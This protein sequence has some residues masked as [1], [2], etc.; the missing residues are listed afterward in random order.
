MIND[1]LLPRRRGRPPAFDRDQVLERAGRTFWRLGYE[2]ASI[3]DLTAAMGLTPQSL[4]AAF[5]SKA[6]LYR[7]TLRRY[8]ATSGAFTP[9]ALREEPTA[10]AAFGRALREAAKQYTRADQPRGCMLSTAVVTC[11]VENNAVAEHVAA[12]RA[13]VL[14]AFKARL[15]RGIKEGDLKPDTNAAALARYLQ[16]VVQGM[17]LQA[18]DGASET[19]LLKVAAIARAE[20][21]R[22]CTSPRS[23]ARSGRRKR[24]SR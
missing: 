5:N 20:L 11:A 15:Q 23:N 24:A 19:E 1:S 18:R 3:A 9:R 2:G 7:E 16:V 14:A 22:Q 17:S 8:R 12:L 4:Y 10:A 6:E 13:E 21:E